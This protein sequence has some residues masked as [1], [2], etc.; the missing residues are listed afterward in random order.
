MTKCDEIEKQRSFDRRG[1]DVVDES[2]LTVDFNFLQPMDNFQ[3][4]V[5][6]QLTPNSCATVLPML[7]LADLSFHVCLEAMKKTATRRLHQSK[8]I[9]AFSTVE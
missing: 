9:L 4:G 7:S 2:K 3:N 1:R 6:I 8:Q 5:F